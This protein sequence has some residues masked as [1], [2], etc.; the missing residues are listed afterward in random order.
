MWNT[1]LQV[2]D[3][4]FIY[5]SVFDIYSRTANLNFHPRSWLY[6][7]NKLV[8]FKLTISSFLQIS[9][10]LKRFGVDES[11][12]LVIPRLRIH[13]ALLQWIRLFLHYS[14]IKTNVN[15]LFLNEYM[16]SSSSFLT[17]NKGHRH[18]IRKKGRFT[19]WQKCTNTLPF[20]PCVDRH[21]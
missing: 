1:I 10:C 5:R 9:K 19:L 16:C 18:W 17:I 2:V 15:S 13:V 7:I 21:Y 20:F 8:Q 6:F 4:V 3:A 14:Y 11:L 12:L